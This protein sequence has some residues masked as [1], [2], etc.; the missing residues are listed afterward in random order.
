MGWTRECF[1]RTGTLHGEHHLP[2]VGQRHL[3]DPKTARI[4]TRQAARN[5][6][7]HPGASQASRDT[8]ADINKKVTKYELNIFSGG[9]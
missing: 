3:S 7:R 5:V 6:G 8:W 9:P 4:N 1:R 2:Q